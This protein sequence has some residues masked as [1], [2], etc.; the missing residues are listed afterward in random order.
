MLKVLDI[1]ARMVLYHPTGEVV[2]P[3]HEERRTIVIEDSIQNL[4]ITDSDKSL[5]R[6]ISEI[7]MQVEPLLNTSG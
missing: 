4:S 3:Y 1:T 2:L 7:C 5:C 6:S